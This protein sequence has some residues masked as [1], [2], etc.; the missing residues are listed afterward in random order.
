MRLLI[1]D[2]SDESI[3]IRETHRISLNNNVKTCMG[4]FGCWVKTPAACIIKDDSQLVG[5]M[6]SESNEVIIVSRCVYGGFSPF[7][8]NVIDRSLSYVHPYFEVYK[9]QICHKRRYQSHFKLRILFYSSNFLDS[10]QRLAEKYAECLAK[11]YQVTD[12]KVNF[13]NR[14]PKEE[15]IAYESSFD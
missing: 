13:Y 9:K 2:L 4:C 6:M 8:K 14:V 7:V 15:D 11:K 12:L 5:Y 10:S 1:D 3:E